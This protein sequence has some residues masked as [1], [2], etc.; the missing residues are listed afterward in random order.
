MNKRSLFLITGIII[1]V[2]C[3]IGII[4]FTQSQSLI[5]AQLIIDT[6]IVQVKHSDGAWVNAENGMLLNQNDAVKTGN[7]TSA[8]IVLFE[9]SILRLDSNTELTLEEIV[10]QAEMKSVT[11]E[12]VGGRTWN[13]I[14]KIGGIDSYEMQ[15]PVAVASVRGTSFCVHVYANGKTIVGVGTGLVNVSVIK[16]YQVHNFTQ[17]KKNESVTIDP[18]TPGQPLIILPFEKDDWILENEQ[19]DEQMREKE[20]S[21][22]YKRIEPYLSQLKQ[23]YGVDDQE[24]EVLIDGYLSGEF[25]LPPDTPDWIR[26]IIEV[27]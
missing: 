13:T 22:L 21:A 18:D 19:M 15:T 12:Q 9:S 2:L 6:G 20:K 24:L 27:S 17:L 4:W 23:N 10:Q 7:N 8:S 3:G 14:S 25:V 26:D 16:E 5:K 1:I 11:I